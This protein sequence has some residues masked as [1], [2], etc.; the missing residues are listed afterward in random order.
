MRDEIKFW[1]RSKRL[2]WFMARAIARKVE[3]QPEML[4]EMSACIER[5][6]ADDPSKGRSLRL[7]RQ[8]VRLSPSKFADAVYVLHAFTKKTQKTEKRDIDI[9]KVRLAELVAT[10]RIERKAK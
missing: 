9:A 5:A 2:D 3:A 6:W 10:L 1:D 7:W 4:R 8:L